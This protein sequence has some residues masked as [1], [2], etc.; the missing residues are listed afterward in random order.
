MDRAMAYEI[1]KV[2][3]QQTG[4]VTIPSEDVIDLALAVKYI[5]DNFDCTQYK[6]V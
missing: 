1:V 3:A 2:L 5:F 4:D 6:M